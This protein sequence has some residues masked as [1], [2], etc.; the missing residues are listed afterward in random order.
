MGTKKVGK[1]FTEWRDIL[2][3]LQKTCSGGAYKMLKQRVQQCQELAAVTYVTYRMLSVSEGYH[4]PD[5]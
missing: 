4:A 1:E 5:M 3:H 2:R